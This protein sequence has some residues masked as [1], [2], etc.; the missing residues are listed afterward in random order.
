MYRVDRNNFYKNEKKSNIY[1]PNYVSEF[2]FK[3]LSTH[4]KEGYIFDPCVGKGSLLIPWEKAGWKIKGVDIEDH[5]FSN[6]IIKNY[7]ELT[8]NDLENKIPSLVIMNPPFNI[9]EK[10]KEYIWKFYGS[11]P[12]LPEVWFRKV[13]ELFGK[14]IPIVMFTPYGFRL[15]QSGESKRWMNF[16]NKNYPEISSIISLPKNV[17]DNVLFH[18][19]I[20]IFNIKT[21]KPHYFL[22]EK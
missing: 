19:E 18:S 16:I 8:N 21:L 20:L 5:N 13:I 2:L 6:T 3:I 11:R 1:T 22:G 17:F 7:L 12:L 14:D 9:D 15:N 4:I 10:T